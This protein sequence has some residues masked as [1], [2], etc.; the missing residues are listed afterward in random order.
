MLLLLPPPPPPKLLPPVGCC[1]A[2]PLPPP[3]KLIMCADGLL[4]LAD[5][6]LDEEDVCPIPEPMPDD[7]NME[8]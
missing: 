6:E 2:S 5:E 7:G 8:E 4:A 3:G 1:A